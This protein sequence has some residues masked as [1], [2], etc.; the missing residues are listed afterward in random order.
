MSKFSHLIAALLLLVAGTTATM[1]QKPLD[2]S[3]QSGNIYRISLKDAQFGN[4]SIAWNPIFYFT[5]YGIQGRII[6]AG[7]GLPMSK[8]VDIFITFNSYPSTTTL[9]IPATYNGMFYEFTL[10]DGIVKPISIDYM[11]TPLDKLERHAAAC[12]IALSISSIKIGNTS[13]PGPFPTKTDFLNIFKAGVAKFPGSSWYADLR[14]DFTAAPSA[15]Q[16][17][18]SNA[19]FSM[20]GTTVTFVDKAKALNY[21]TNA[22]NGWGECRLGAIT[23]SGAGIAVYK[24]NGYANTGNINHYLISKLKELNREGK[25][26][27]SITM[28]TSGYFCIIFGRNGWYGIVPDGMNT[29]LNQFNADREAILS[30]SIAENGSYVIVTD[31]H[32][33]ASNST[34]KSNLAKAI[35]RFGTL[36]SAS[37]TNLGL[38]AICQNGVYYSKIPKNLEERLKSINFKP[39][40]ISFTDSG[41]FMITNESGRCSYHM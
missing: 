29:K 13:L 21:L 38:I 25:T 3:A 35:E 20:Y 26:I 28:T 27:N 37:I 14:K 24:K 34:D 40:H 10:R 19:L 5:P 12:F 30:V 9:T 15:S 23:E 16:Q 6:A 33:Y 32:Y 4:N 36:Y 1:A 11:N 8:K 39:G 2:I 41:T 7:N 31:K 18:S 17:S 22:I